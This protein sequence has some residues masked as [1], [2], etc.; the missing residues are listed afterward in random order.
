M[1]KYNGLHIV[2]DD[3]EDYHGFAVSVLY[4]N[5]H[6]LFLYAYLS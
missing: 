3:M 6:Y 2:A 4:L 5:T 1:E